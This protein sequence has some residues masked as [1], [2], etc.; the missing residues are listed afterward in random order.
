VKVV[1]RIPMRV[2]VDTSDKNLQSRSPHGVVPVKGHP[3]DVDAARVSSVAAISR[4][5]R[6]RLVN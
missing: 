1:Q 3:S 6:K 5:P 2:R 4:A